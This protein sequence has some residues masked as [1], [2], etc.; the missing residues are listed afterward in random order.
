MTYQEGNIFAALAQRRNQDRKDVKTIKKITT[1]L[2]LIHSFRQI[3]VCGSDQA[4]I[5][6]RRS[7]TAK[8]LEFLLLENPQELGLQLRR[9]IANLVEKN[10]AVVR[11]LEAP[12]PLSY[13]AGECAPFMTEQFTFKQARGYSGAVYFDQGALAARAQ[14]VNGARK[15]FFACARLAQKQNCGIRGATVSTCFRIRFRAWLSPMISAK[16]CSLR[17]SSCR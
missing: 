9:D 5:H 15:Q 3:H 16:L 12:N 2:F 6:T 17:I 7:R 10:R 4:D 8:A 11:Q 13:R 1:E 14:I